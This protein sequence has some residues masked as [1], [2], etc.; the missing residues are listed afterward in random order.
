MFSVIVPTYNRPRQLERCLRALDGQT[1]LTAPYEVIVVNDG[2]DRR[3]F[4]ETIGALGLRQ[5]VRAITQRNTG[6]AGARNHGAR[7]AGGRYLAFIDDDCAAA[8]EWLASLARAFEAHPEAALGGATINALGANMY[9]E[10]S[11]LL[12]EYLNAYYN[13]DPEDCVFFTS[14]NLAVPAA[15]FREMGGFDTNYP[16]AAAEDREFCSHWRYLGRR[17]VYAPQAVVHHYHN[18]SLR[19]FIR[20]H[21][22]YGRGARRF[23]F[24]RAARGQRRPRIEPASFY[25]GML[26]WPRRFHRGRKGWWLSGLMA[27]TQ[28]AHT[29]GFVAEVMATSRRKQA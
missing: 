17:L 27:L 11:Q 3:L 26:G 1:G 25:W 22:H 8:P 9:S 6:P 21:Y 12:T 20:Q 18:L 19:S 24:S 13:R 16:L 5:P 23:H 7:V 29:A 15:A 2:G 14:N 28:V 10:A 4:E